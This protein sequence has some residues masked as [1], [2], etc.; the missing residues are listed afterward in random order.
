MKPSRASAGIA[1]L[2]GL[3]G[4]LWGILP[5]RFKL[6]AGTDAWSAAAVALAGRFPHPE[7]LAALPRSALPAGFEAMPF[8]Q[9]LEALRRKPHPAAPGGN[10]PYLT[11]YLEAALSSPERLF[12]SP[13]AIPASLRAPALVCR[14]IL[15][16]G[17]FGNVLLATCEAGACFAVKLDVGGNARWQREVENLQRL[18]ECEHIVRYVDH[19]RL[20]GVNYLVTEHVPGATLAEEIEQWSGQSGA[21]APY[22]ADAALELLKH[23]AAALGHAHG[24]PGGGA[25]AHRDLKPDNILLASRGGRPMLKVLDFGMSRDRERQAAMTEDGSIPPGTPYYAAPEAFEGCWSARSDVYAFGLIAHELL[26]GVHADYPHGMWL[27]GMTGLVELIGLR[28]ARNG[29]PELR[30]LRSELSN[31]L[32]DLLDDCCRRTPSER[33][34]DGVELVR[35]LAG[36]KEAASVAAAPARGAAGRLRRQAELAF[37][38][39]ALSELLSGDAILQARA[40]RSVAARLERWAAAAR[41]G[42]AL[43]HRFEEPANGFQDAALAI[44]TVWPDGADAPNDDLPAFW[45]GTLSEVLRTSVLQPLLTLQF[46]A[47]DR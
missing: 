36:I 9:L 45:K 43:D 44:R 7:T 17:A 30:L 35:R 46:T 29:L 47:N 16:E 41:R 31:A 13:V 10:I 6:S 28:S 15:G 1:W 40:W 2:R 12:K 25:V 27:S 24:A 20:L 5:D 21:G 22:P 34:A 23:L 26:V 14:T 33:P 32:K 18:S 39:N 42:I 4:S 3:P 38:D 11:E 19:G 37:S 8:E